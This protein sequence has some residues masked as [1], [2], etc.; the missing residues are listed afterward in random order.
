[1]GVNSRGR[2]FAHAVAVQ[3]LWGI[4]RCHVAARYATATALLLT[5][6]PRRVAI[7][8]GTP[9][10]NLT[11]VPQRAEIMNYVTCVPSRAAIKT[12]YLTCLPRRV[13]ITIN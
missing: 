1:M 8:P 11:S 7:N 2:A 5:G 10:N 9:E 13:A 3:S 6:L 12:N 4:S